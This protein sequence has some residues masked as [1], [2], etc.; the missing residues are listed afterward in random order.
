MKGCLVIVALAILAFAL[1][2][3]NTGLVLFLGGSL[4]AFLCLIYEVVNSVSNNI[5]EE[6]ARK[7]DGQ[8]PQANY[9]DKGHKANDFEAI[10]GREPV[11]DL[12]TAAPAVK[13]PT[14][15]RLSFHQ[16][17]GI[18]QAV[19]RGKAFC[20]ELSEDAGL[21]EDFFKSAVNSGTYS[22]YSADN[23]YTT[24]KFFF[25]NDL[26]DCFAHLGHKVSTLAKTDPVDINY[27]LAEGQA[28]YVTLAALTNDKEEFSNYR[29]EMLSLNKTDGNPY[30]TKIRQT[31]EK[32]LPIY[33]NSGASITAEGVE[34]FNLVI[35]LR[36]FHREERIPEIRQ[37]LYDFA[38][39]LALSDNDITM[40]EREWL[41]ELKEK[42]LTK[43]IPQ[44][45]RA[46][47]EP[48]ARQEANPAEGEE[49]TD[50]M[51]KLNQLVGLHEVKVE[52]QSL[53]R[54]IA[55]NKKRREAGLRVAAISYHCVFAGNPGTGK[56]TVARI[57]AGIYKQLGILN[58]GQLVE[59]DRS[60]LVAEYVGQTA[61][62]TNKIID[63]AIG[64]VLFIDEAY[65]LAQG[66]ENDYGREAI[67]TLLKRMEDDRDRLVVI[68]A[69]YTNEIEAFI[70]TNPG[71]RSRFNR[72][73]HFEDY[74]E[75]ELFQIFQLQAKKYDYRLDD[76][77]EAALRQLLHRKTSERHK[78]FGNARFVRNL[79]EGVIERQAVRLSAIER[80]DSESLA[81]ITADDIHE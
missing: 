49:E 27:H 62:K 42:I 70:N 21:R 64:G 76:G 31:I 63:K 50:Y 71:L 67:A 25:A 12:P 68:L 74:S 39:T 45:P 26:F 28:L 6:E 57:L 38:N 34:E 29:E 78:D 73:V 4:I 53:T 65:T 17:E 3:E 47:V 52:L 14:V 48:E 35:L 46:G 60:G 22:S 59:T 37:T 54:F 58:K 33:L 55:V 79:F 20:R 75:E 43:S 13:N 16:F 7:A 1:F 77:A 81:T 19:A 61:V 9:E 44:Q 8:A 36:G 69:G 15:V 10:Q 41:D 56:T 40:E 80:P 24:L 66:G 18:K 32:T 2:G 72:Y 23:F 5:K 30:N 51:E 11:E